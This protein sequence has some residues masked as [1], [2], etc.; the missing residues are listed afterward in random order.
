M[1]YCGVDEVGYGALAGP[2]TAVA[3]SLS[4]DLPPHRLI[5]HW[6]MS[7]VK[8]SKK[9]TGPQRERLR[10]ELTGFLVDCGASVGIGHADVDFINQYGYA[11]ARQKSWED[12]VH[13][14]TTED[15]VSPLQL[16]VDGDVE[17]N[18]CLWDQRLEHKADDRFF[19]VAA[20]SILA[21]ILRD[22]LMIEL[23]KH[24]PV[25]GFEKHKGYGTAQHID[26]LEKYG[27]SPAHRIQPCNTVLKKRAA[28]GRKV[29]AFGRPRWRN[30]K[31]QL[32]SML[33]TK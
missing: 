2:I 31:R 21:K 27:L 33:V 20:A 12:A 24:H 4:V 10:T 23:A 11:K 13:G 18:D 32:R 17:L 22:D 8:D 15:G 5:A 14:A 25:Y 6:P 19:I 9:T 7:S 29:P 30:R 1:I 16:I 26:A 3:C 28:A